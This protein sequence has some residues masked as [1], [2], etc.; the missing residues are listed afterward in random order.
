MLTQLRPVSA[1][2]KP[3]NYVFFNLNREGIKNRS[4]Y[5]SKL[6]EGAEIKYTWRSLEPQK[7]LYDF[8]AIEKDISFLQSKGKRLF[9]QLQDVS[10]DPKIVNVPTYITNDPEYAGGANLQYDFKD[11]KD[12]E[13]KEM[14]WV[15]RRW[16]KTVRERYTI[17]LDEIA[18][19][20]D[21]RIEGIVLP[22]T[23]VEFGM[24]GKYFP[25]KYNPEKYRNSIIEIMKAAHNAFKK[26]LVLQYANFMP[27]EWLPW[28]DKGYL[29]SIFE[30]AQSL[31]IGIGGP[32]IIPYK[33]GQM[34]HSYYFAHKYYGKIKLGYAV[35]EGNYSQMNARTGK[36]MTID[37]IYTFASE[38]L[39]SDYIFWYPE[40]PYF[41]KN[42]V[43]YLRTRK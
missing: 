34:N 30:E 40:E 20:F 17:L 21:G 1:E 24:T 41:S 35:Q 4:F 5:D 8:S 6:F 27:G 19:Q 39:K 25:T 38:Y 31:K 2:S 29:A 13:P 11:D 43:P 36:I 12:N 3:K 10:F 42:V 23:S 37:D 28:D 14:G 16:D 33:K 9:I 18:N 15:S 7:G 22:E 32:D 26:S